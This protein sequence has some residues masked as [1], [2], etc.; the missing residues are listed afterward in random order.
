MV[1][2]DFQTNT[3]RALISDWLTSTRTDVASVVIL[4]I[5]K[6]FI[7]QQRNTDAMHVISLAITQA[8]AFRKH[9]KTS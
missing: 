7:V 4:C 6:A 9:S 3:R 1:N 5:L 8:C 2:K